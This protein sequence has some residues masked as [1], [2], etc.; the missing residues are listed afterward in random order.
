MQVISGLYDTP[1]CGGWCEGDL[2]S[3]RQIFGNSTKMEIVVH[4]SSGHGINLS[5]NA[6]G[7]YQAI[8][9]FLERYGL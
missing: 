3:T 7:A 8:G 1:F 6:T 4:P 2:E 5:F 9:D